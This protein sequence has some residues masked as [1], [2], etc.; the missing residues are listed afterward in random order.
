MAALERTLNN[1]HRKK[2]RLRD[3]YLNGAETVEE[4]ARMKQALDQEEQ[5]LAQRM[6]ALSASNNA[7]DSSAMLRSQIS[8]TLEILLS[9]DADIEQKYVA[10]NSI[11]ERC[12]FSK[13]ENLLS[14]T[15]RLVF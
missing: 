3:A 6:A 8:G 15:Y 12:T 9:P 2:D 5:S 7:V 13:E 1:L 11:I 14:I 10:L 4:Y